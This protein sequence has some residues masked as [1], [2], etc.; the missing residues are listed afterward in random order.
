MDKRLNERGEVIQVA[1]THAEW[2][3]LREPSGYAFRREGWPR[4]LVSCPR[5]GKV[6]VPVT[7]ADRVI[8]RSSTAPPVT[9]ARAEM[10]DPAPEP[11]GSAAPTLSIPRHLLGPDAGI[12]PALGQRR[13]ELGS[14]ADRF[15]ARAFGAASPRAL[16]A[17]GFRSLASAAGFV[18]AIDLRAR[19]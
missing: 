18:G 15:K 17:V 16:P 13:D 4:M 19:R 11:P 9:P 6:T 12:P 10:A 14:G 5:R 3:A 7:F 2:Q 1:M 8:D